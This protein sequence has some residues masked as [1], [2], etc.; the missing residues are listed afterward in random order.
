ML[1]KKIKMSILG[2]LTLLAL[3]AATLAQAAA[4]EGRGDKHLPSWNP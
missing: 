4:I 2:E 1:H 3:H